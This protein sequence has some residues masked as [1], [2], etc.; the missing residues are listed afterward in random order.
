MR[1]GEVDERAV[2]LRARDR[3]GQVPLERAAVVGLENL[4][5][6]PVEVGAREQGVRDLELSAEALEHEH[7]VGVLLAHAGDDVVPRLH[8]SSGIM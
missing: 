6:G 1:L 4:G 8:V 2:L 3:A 7:G 5:V